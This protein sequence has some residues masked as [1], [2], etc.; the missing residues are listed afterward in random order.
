LIRAARDSQITPSELVRLC[1]DEGFPKPF[2]DLCLDFLLRGS[3]V[4]VSQ[5][6][7]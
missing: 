3:Q 2:A 1:N 7:A 5:R 6:I 4:A